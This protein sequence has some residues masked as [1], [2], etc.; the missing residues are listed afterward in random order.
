MPHAQI[1]EE[2]HPY[3][4]RQLVGRLATVTPTGTPHLTPIWYMILDGGLYVG[5]QAT[6]KKYRN[7]VANRAVSFC[8]DSGGRETDIE[9]VI[10]EGRA[11]DVDD[12]EIL[13]KWNEKLLA[14]YFGGDSQHP[15]YLRIKAMPAPKILRIVPHKVW[16]LDATSERKP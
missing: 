12:P 4:E 11:E 14:R 1:P 5:T 16:T 7:I 10:I 6:R 13:A 9:A 3:L 8:V 15:G 2:W